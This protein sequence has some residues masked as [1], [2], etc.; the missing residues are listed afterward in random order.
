MHW[1]PL[2]DCEG[3]DSSIANPTVE[4]LT[5][6]AIRER[7]YEMFDMALTVADEHSLPLWLEET[8]PTSCPGTNETSRTHAQ[9]LWTA[10]F[11]MTAMESGVERLALHSTLNACQGGAPMSPVCAVG[12]FEDPGQIIGG[13][14][15]FLALMMLGWMPDG[16]VMSPSVSG[17]GEIMVHG[18]AGDD[19][20][21]AVMIVDLRETEEDTVGVDIDLEG[22]TGSWELSQGALLTGTAL[23][24]GVSSLGAL[25]PVEGEFAGAELSTSETL[26]VPS[27]AGS[28]TLLVLEAAG[29]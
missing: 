24:A 6:P 16:S 23:D 22:D 3:P 10:D 9:A 20:S 4:D 2:W 17:D 25:A 26:T 21:L 29:D 27:Q 28:V 8:G 1:Y 13:R 18:V 15:S 7:A 12:P 19:G 14:T 11:V 5:S